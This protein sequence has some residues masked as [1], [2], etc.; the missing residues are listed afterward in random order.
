[1]V[2]WRLQSIFAWNYIRKS[3]IAPPNVTEVAN[4]RVYGTYVRMLSKMYQAKG[5]VQMDATSGQWKKKSK[6][7][8]FSALTDAQ[9]NAS[10]TTTN[11]VD[12][13]FMVQF[14]VHLMMHLEMNFKIYKRCTKRCTQDCIKRCG[15]GCTWFT[16]VYTIV[17]VYECTMW[18]SKRWNWGST[19]CCNWK[20]I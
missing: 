9:Q 20:R 11:I 4:E 2:Q 3:Q 10:G 14:R 1:M 7:G 17:N 16:L 5:A 8:I 15:S 13:H 18:L 19:L 12:V 6:S